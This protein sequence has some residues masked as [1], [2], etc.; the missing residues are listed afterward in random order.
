VVFMGYIDDDCAIMRK[1]DDLIR[2]LNT[3]YIGENCE[4]PI[5]GSVGIAVYPEDGIHYEQLIQC[6]DRALY[7][8]KNKGKN[9]YMV[10]QSII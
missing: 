9:N 2:A 5:S 1:A 6:A 7:Q 10:Y 4:I 8:V 3:T